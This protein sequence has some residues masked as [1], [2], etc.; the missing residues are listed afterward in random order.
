[1]PAVLQ[2]C[3]TGVS[4]QVWASNDVHV[5][6]PRP[7]LL[8]SRA[9]LKGQIRQRRPLRRVKNAVTEA[10]T[11]GVADAAWSTNKVL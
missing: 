5:L 11:A 9:A 6:R 7:L 1:M 10:V 2:G 8:E 4:K 3:A